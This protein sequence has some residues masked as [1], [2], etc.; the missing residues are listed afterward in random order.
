MISRISIDDFLNKAENIPIVDVRSPGEF[1]NGHI[2]GAVNIPVFNDEERVRVG[3]L[4]KKNGRDAAVYLGFEIVGPKM[5]NLTAEARSIAVN[6]ELLIHC[7]RGGMRSANMAWL[8][9]NIGIRSL[10]LTGG[11]KAYRK[12]I[13]ERMAEKAQIIILSGMTG[14]GKTEI[15]HKME[16][17]GEQILDLENL[18]HH[19]GSAFGSLGQLPQLPNEQFQNQIF[20]KWKKL[21]IT[22]RIWIEDESRCIG[23]N[24]IPD[25]LYLQMRNANVIMIDV[26]KKIRIKRLVEEYACFDKELLRESILKIYRRVGG[27]NAEEAFLCLDNND[28]ESVSDIVLTYYDKAYKHGLSA[29]DKELVNVLKISDYNHEKIAELLINFA[30]KSEKHGND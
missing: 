27:Q 23:T 7:W 24:F 28:F 22:R 14:S 13:K 20:E 29:R 25:E 15:L 8:F 5:K 19:K 16:S 17:K 18:S 30:D 21:D 9:S 10:V 11:Y 6:N 2:P 26:D 1:L 3:T 4:Y 12:Y